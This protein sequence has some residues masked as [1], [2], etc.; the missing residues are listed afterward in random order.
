M[1][2]IS[3]FRMLMVFSVALARTAY[4]R[5]QPEYV[6]SDDSLSA[7]VSVTISYATLVLTILPIAYQDLGRYSN[8]YFC[9]N[10]SGFNLITLPDIHEHPPFYIGVYAMAGVATKTV[11]V[12]LTVIQYNSIEG[13]KVY[14]LQALDRHPARHDGLA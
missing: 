5:T 2:F 14:F 13:V 10:A 6:M 4:A 9:V 8:N 12:L 7:V 1:G 11:S 3:L